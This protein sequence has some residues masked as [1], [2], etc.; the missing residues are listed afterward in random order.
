VQRQSDSKDAIAQGLGWFSVGLGAVQVTAPR[1]LAKLIGIRSG[2]N[3]ALMRAMGVRE[4]ATGVGILARPRPAA[5]LWAR[6]AGDA[7]DLGLLG[8]S[9]AAGDDVRKR[10]LF[11]AIAAVAGVTAPDALEA[12]R[13]S[14][15]TGGSVHVKKSITVNK[16]PDEVYGFWRDFENLPR[17]MTHL[18]SV[19]TTGETRSHWR[20]KGP[21]GGSVEWDAEIVE[22][23]PDELI[24]WRSLPGADVQNSGS[25]RFAAA[26]GGRGT[27]LVVEL[28]YAPPA[29]KAGRVAAKLLGEEP[30]TQLADDLRRFKQVV[31]TGEVVR[32]DGTPHGHS[33]ADHLRQRAAQPLETA[34]AT[35]G[36]R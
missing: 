28:D 22:E 18:E 19:Q 5:W 21:A 23:R 11:G 33:L 6:V 36:A 35:G 34:D 17:F 13:L 31:E 27:E 1:A 29:G 24:A 3:P 15:A 8:A 10:R 26:P 25:V 12:M 2:G 7:L 20:A 32:S 16:P 9:A 4:I 30:A 14:R